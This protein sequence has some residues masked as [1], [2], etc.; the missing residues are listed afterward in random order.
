MA[1]MDIGN[2]KKRRILI[3]FIALLITSQMRGQISSCDC[4]SPV[5][6]INCYHDCFREIISRN[7]DDDYIIRFIAKP[8]FDPEYAFQ[9][10][11]K[12][13]LSFELECLVF[14]KNLWYIKNSDSL[15]FETYR[16][17]IE[18][19]IA[20]NLNALFDVLTDVE[21]EDVLVTAEDGISFIFLRK[22]FAGIKCSQVFN[23][24]EQ[25]P[26]GKVIVLCDH[27]VRYAKGELPEL[28]PEKTLR[29]VT[30]L[31]YF[32]KQY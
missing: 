22:S 21:G 8:T 23:P 2:S 25:T 3:C 24:N 9:I 29:T 17:S 1:D 6:Q 11:Q 4:V 28:E 15:S 10:R 18:K 13:S 7:L 32:L 16:R 5:E 14:Q 27:L 12:D 19:E 26:L 20:C 31:L 30:E